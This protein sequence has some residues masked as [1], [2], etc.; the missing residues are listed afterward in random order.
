MRYFGRQAFALYILGLSALLLWLSFFSVSRPLPPL[1]ADSSLS[2]YFKH[3]QLAAYTADGRMDYYADFDQIS[4][5]GDSEVTY[6][7]GIKIRYLEPKAR[8]DLTADKGRLYEERNEIY[9][10]AAVEI[11]SEEYGH[12]SSAHSRVQTRD[13]LI[14]IARRSAATTA[15]VSIHQ[16]RQRLSGMGMHADLATGKI[17]ILNDVKVSRE[18]DL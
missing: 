13:V 12:E 17:K 7:R 4:R 10:P 6:L 11:F 2:S 15:P 8:T 3:V 14:D 18:D 1:L 5:H 9:L 16:D